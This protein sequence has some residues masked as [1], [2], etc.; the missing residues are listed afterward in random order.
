[1]LKSQATERQFLGLPSFP[2]MSKRAGVTS[3]DAPTLSAW[4]AQKHVKPMQSMLHRLDGWNK[5]PR[6][7]DMSRSL[8]LT[9]QRA[10]CLGE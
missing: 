10:A 4:N 2:D 5:T 8:F 6:W 3:F 9:V 7:V 1:M